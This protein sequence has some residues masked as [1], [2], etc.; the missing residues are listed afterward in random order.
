MFGTD[1]M[2]ISAIKAEFIDAKPSV[3]DKGKSYAVVAA[4][5]ASKSEVPASP[6]LVSSPLPA[7][8]DGSAGEGSAPSKRKGTD[9][10]TTSAKNP[11]ST[12]AAAVKSRTRRVS[13]EERVTRVAD[14]LCFYCGRPGHSVSACLKLKAKNLKKARGKQPC[15]PPATD[16]M[17]FEPGRFRQEPT[18]DSD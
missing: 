16:P 17:D 13:E 18:S 9:T 7:S 2:L 15:Q 8:D 1:L 11:R 5:A 14:G 3:A 6:L 4:A 10:N 12:A